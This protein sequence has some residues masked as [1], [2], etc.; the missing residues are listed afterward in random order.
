MEA[1]AVDSQDLL[2]RLIAAAGLRAKVTSANIANL[3]T[4]GYVRQEVKFEG[5]LE[6]AMQRGDKAVERVQPMVVED[7]ATPARPDGNNVT[8]EL[9]LNTMRENRILME[10]YLTIMDSQFNLLQSAITGGR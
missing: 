6:K 2:K 9:E 10:T 4:P 3:N 5:L 8:L 1:K 7:T